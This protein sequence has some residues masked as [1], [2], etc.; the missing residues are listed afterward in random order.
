MKLIASAKTKEQMEQMINTYFFSTKY[1]LADN[2][3]IMHPDKTIKNY[4]ITEKKNRF[5][6]EEI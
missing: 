2:L 5:R 4:R 3:T 6:F 1:T